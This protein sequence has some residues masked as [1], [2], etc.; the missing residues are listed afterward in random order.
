MTEM[1]ASSRSSGFIA[2]LEK[3]DAGDRARLKRNAGKTIAEAHEAMGLFYG[4]LPPGV[5]HYQE[6]VYFLVATLF[7]LAEGGGKGD[8]GNHLVIAQNSKN[9]KGLDRR[10][11]I[12]LDADLNQLHF[13]LRQSV[14]FLQSC[15][16]HVNWV[17]LLDDLLQ[18]NHPDRFIQQRWARSYFG[19][20]SNDQKKE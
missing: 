9:S 12:L 7:P 17:Q 5:S 20:L 13:R 18:W 11:E 15:R 1:V 16:V 19:S 6:E 14:H 8:F 4:L 3:T 2:R 10:V